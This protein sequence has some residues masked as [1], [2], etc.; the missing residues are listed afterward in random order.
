MIEVKE[1]RDENKRQL[2]QRISDMNAMKSELDTVNK[3]RDYN[4]PQL[5]QIMSE[6]AV[7]KKNRDENKRLLQV[8][9]NYVK[10]FKNEL[11]VPQKDRDDS[12]PRVVIIWLLSAVMC[13]IQISD[14]GIIS[15]LETKCEFE[16]N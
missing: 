3:D 12:E 15:E 9:I 16:F 8:H 7:A 4:K 11:A 1:E 14:N 2:D 13:F 6:L 10:S 5:D